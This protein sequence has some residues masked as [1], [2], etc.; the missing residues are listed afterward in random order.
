MS[1]V[2]PNIFTNALGMTLCFLGLILAHSSGGIDRSWRRENKKIAILRTP[3]DQSRRGDG[4]AAAR[5]GDGFQ[6]T[7]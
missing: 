6:E 5:R 2:M 4:A 1:I 7:D 3:G